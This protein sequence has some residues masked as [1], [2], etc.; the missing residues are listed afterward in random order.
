[1]TGTKNDADKERLDLLPMRAI[2]EVGKVLTFGAKKYA[3]NNWRGGMKWG[4][5]VGAT[6][7]HV[8]AF[9][10]GENTD[11]ESGLHHLA[12][13]ATDILCVLEYTI[14]HTGADDRFIYETYN[15]RGC[16]GDCDPKETCSCTAE[17]LEG[18]NQGKE[19][20]KLAF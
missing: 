11:K 18:S 5:L 15:K 19:G 7:R 3:D 4:R 8:F 17:C 9:M 12:H 14:T 2:N 1:M 16:C 13:A 6:L 10:G 20:D